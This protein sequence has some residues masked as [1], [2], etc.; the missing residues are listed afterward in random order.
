METM[1]LLVIVIGFGLVLAVL[2]ETIY[3]L[4]KTVSSQNREL[5]ALAR[6]SLIADVSKE[7][8]SAGRLILA[9]DKLDGLARSNL[10]PMEIKK[11]PEQP[12]SGVEFTMGNIGG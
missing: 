8:P 1:I 10:K 11:Q 7:N 12:T 6:E 4:T 3:L 9:S 5:C 2:L